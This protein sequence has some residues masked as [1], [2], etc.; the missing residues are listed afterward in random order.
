MTSRAIHNFLVESN[1]IEGIHEPPTD[2]QIVEFERFLTLPEVTVEELRLFVLVFQPDA[3]LRDRPGLNV[4]VGNHFPPGGDWRMRAWLE[5]I[6]TDAHKGRHP[7]FVHHAYETLHP[8]TDGNG[9]SGRALWAWQMVNQD[10]DHCIALNRGFLW[11]WYYQSLE[12]G[13]KR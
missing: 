4:R 7:F 13:G 8:F 10:H 1:R 6:L 5:L 2:E 11:Q 3:E 12:F 9:R